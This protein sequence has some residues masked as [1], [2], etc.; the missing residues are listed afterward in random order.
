[1]AVRG[2]YLRPNVI[3][4]YDVSIDGQRFLLIKD[5]TVEGDEAVQPAQ[6]VIVLN[7]FEELRRRVPTP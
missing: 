2:D 1:M 6:F 4:Q 3:R 7:F 5:A